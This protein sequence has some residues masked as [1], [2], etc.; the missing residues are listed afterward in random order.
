MRFGVKVELQDLSLHTLINVMN[1]VNKIM[2]QDNKA[3]T[4]MLSLSNLGSGK[5]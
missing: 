2:P 5:F 3:E 1:Y 4:E